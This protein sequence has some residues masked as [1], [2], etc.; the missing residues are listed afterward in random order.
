MFKRFLILSFSAMIALSF[1]VSV[2]SFWALED[3]SNVVI[4][5]RSQA[6]K[7]NEWGRVQAN[8][9]EARIQAIKYMNNTNLNQF[10]VDSFKQRLQTSLKL[11]SS[12]PKIKSELKSYNDLFQEYIEAKKDWMSI[13]KDR[14][15]SYKELISLKSTLSKEVLIS[16]I[17]I[18]STYIQISHNPSDLALTERFN[19][20]LDDEGFSSN[21]VS[22]F[23][24]YKMALSKSVK[25][26]ILMD[27]IRASHLDVLGPKLSL[28]SENEKLSNM[29]NQDI[30]GPI[31]NDLLT[32]YKRYAI[33]FGLF[34]VAILSF[35]ARMIFNR[36]FNSL[37][38]EPEE[39]ARLMKEISQGKLVKTK[40]IERAK[41]ILGDL[42]IMNDS[43]IYP[44]MS[45][46]QGSEEIRSQQ[47][48]SLHSMTENKNNCLNEQSSVE[49]LA[50]ASTELASTASDVAEN[51][52][53]AEQAALEANEVILSGQDT[54]NHS[55][56]TTESISNSIIEAQKIVINLREHSE[57]ISSVVDVIN[58]IS[59]Q[60]NLLAL[61]AA[62]E[63]ARAGEQGRGFAVVADEVRALAG[64]TQQST[65][66][67]QE[68]ISQ[69][70]EQSKQADESMSKN[71]ELMSMTRLATEELAKSFVIISE[72]VASISDVNAI[73]ATASEEQSAV[74]KDISK[75]LEDMSVLVQKNLEGIEGTVSSSERVMK[76][77]SNL[78]LDM[79]F[80]RIEDKRF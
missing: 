66:D 40:E 22:A 53:K 70:Q 15:E 42:A 48:S 60:T 51:A 41:G 7:T 1:I 47:K 10:N 79:D 35:N 74:T 23:S 43:L 31:L 36:V 61:N 69:L 59:E 77:A 34:F 62:I 72:K 32:E 63:A 21:E 44:I 3:L 54:L 4:K 25:A 28:Q 17:E 33:F 46:R 78:K 71:V 8:V 58:S 39:I 52:Q 38:G 75:Q 26:L 68:I 6:L 64:K 67:I 24:I 14:N 18:E 57:K 55:T 49:Q 27:S 65:I 76:L 45:V 20:A 19:I 50:T 37:G 11:S 13:E 29:K 56:Q 30:I 16:L 12:H 5:Y 2:S 80:F 9:L 73:V